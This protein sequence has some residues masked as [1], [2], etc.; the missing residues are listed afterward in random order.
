M[1]SRPLRLL[2]ICSILLFVMTIALWARGYFARDGLWYTPDSTRYGLH[3][4]RGRI[5]AWT[6]TVAPGPTAMVWTSPAK[7]R[8]GFVWD[9]APDSWYD[10]FIGFRKGP[11][12]DRDF[13]NAPSLGGPAGKQ[14]LGLRYVHND[15]WFPLAQ[16]QQGYPAARSRALFVPHWMIALL[17]ALLPAA[18]LARSAR[19]RRRRRRGHCS[20]CGYDLRATPGRCPECGSTSSQPEPV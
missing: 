17:T 3:S 7:M 18:W 20:A 1:R 11:D 10:Q 14:F 5:W 19:A 6:L 16:L 12:L 4:Y 15:A 13:L 2:T 8:A 9:S